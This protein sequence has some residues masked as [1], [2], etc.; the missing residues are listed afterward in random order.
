M[1]FEESS[2]RVPQ[3]AHAFARPQRQA[4]ELFQ[5][6]AAAIEEPVEKSQSNGIDLD[7]RGRS[8][9]FVDINRPVQHRRRLG[10]AKVHRQA[11]PLAGGPIERFLHDQDAPPA[12]VLLV[13]SP[14]LATSDRSQCPVATCEWRLAP[15]TRR[16]AVS[17]R[18]SAIT[19]PRIWPPSANQSVF[20]MP[21]LSAMAPAMTGAMPPPNT[22]P[23]PMTR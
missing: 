18:N 17:F 9:G 6:P 8:D 10:D 16:G 14:T 5:L 12:V 15:P 1:R 22:S 4:V 11:D 21:E 2:G 19:V 23:A 3:E 13:A 20:W 7:L